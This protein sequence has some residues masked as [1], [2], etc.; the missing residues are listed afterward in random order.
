MTFKASNTSPE[1]Y[2]NLIAFG[3]PKSYD[4]HPRDGAS[5]LKLGSATASRPYQFGTTGG[6]RTRTR[7]GSAHRKERVG[8]DCRAVPLS[9][10]SRPRLASTPLPKRLPKSYDAH[11]RDGASRLKLGSA[12]ASRP[13]QFGTTGAPNARTA[14]QRLSKREGRDGSP[15]RPIIAA[16]P[17]LSCKRAAAKTTSEILRRPSPRR[18]FAPEVWVRYGEPTLPIWNEQKSRINS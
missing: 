1:K 4:A 17:P 18:R 9:R 16:K 3:L 15:S 7:R 12:T 8:M 2:Q 6:R 13:Y 10:R 5:R 14:R 11:P